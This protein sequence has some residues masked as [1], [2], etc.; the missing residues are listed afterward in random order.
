MIETVAAQV[1]GQRGPEPARAARRR[2]A[3][4]RLRQLVR[5][6]GRGA[7]RTRA[8]V[9]VHARRGDARPA[10]TPRRAARIARRLHLVPEQ[11][12]ESRGRQLPSRHPRVQR[13]H[14]SPLRVGSP[15]RSSAAW[16]TCQ[17]RSVSASRQPGLDCFAVERGEREHRAAAHGRLVVACGE[18]DR[19]ARSDRR[20]R[21]ARR[22]PPR[23]RAGRRGR[24]RATERG[25]AR[26]PSRAAFAERERG[27][28]GDERVV[29]GEQGDQRPRPPRRLRARGRAPPR[30]GARPG[31]DPRPRPATS[32]RRRV[33]TRRARARRARPRAPAA[34]GSVARE[35]FELVTPVGRQLGRRGRATAA[36]AARLDRRCR[37]HRS[38][39]Y[40]GRSTAVG[41]S[42]LASERLCYR[43][44]VRVPTSI[45][46][47]VGVGFRT[48]RHRPPATSPSCGPVMRLSR[49]VQV[50]AGQCRLRPV[51]AG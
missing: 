51:S 44:V 49:S 29:V 17:S 11:P 46:R 41:A 32:R 3:Q 38:G 20:A 48:G 2:R 14:R 13:S 50:E 22:R 40:S 8:G 34:S 23:A 16:R 33:A 1:P 37:S 36:R 25:D 18:H 39:R 12:P 7:R 15:R 27:G 47:L 21:R 43:R 5:A 28:L 4:R 35:S 45:A 10:V 30:A 31:R 42:A 19:R 9:G 26:G 6:D 24:G